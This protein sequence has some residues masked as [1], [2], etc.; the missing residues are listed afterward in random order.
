MSI[1]TFFI[2]ASDN[3]PNLEEIKAKIASNSLEEKTQA[4]KEL[5]KCMAN[6]EAYPSII[7]H[8]ITN[9]IPNQHKSN[10][11]RKAALLYWEIVEKAKSPTDKTLKEEVFLACNS[12][13]NDLIGHN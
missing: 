7:M 6:D 13:R 8:V 2:R 9:I 1:C 11:L 4:L 3:P 5:I 12:L 10:E